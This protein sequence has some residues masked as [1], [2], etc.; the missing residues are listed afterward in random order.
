MDKIYKKIDDLIFLIKQKGDRTEYK[1]LVL[2]NK[3]ESKKIKQLAIK[4]RWVL[5]SYLPSLTSS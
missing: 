3:K 1:Y 4:I 2:N 5:P